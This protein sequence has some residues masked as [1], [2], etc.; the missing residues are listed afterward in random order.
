MPRR[1]PN[2]GTR[3]WLASCAPRR[4]RGLPQ[5]TV[6]PERRQLREHVISRRQLPKQSPCEPVRF[7]SRRC[8]HNCLPTASNGASRV[9]RFSEQGGVSGQRHHCSLTPGNGGAVTSR[10]DMRA[11]NGCMNMRD[12]EG[13]GWE[14]PR[15]VS[16]RAPD[17]GARRIERVDPHALLAVGT[18][19][20]DVA[21]REVLEFGLLLASGLVSLFSGLVW[22]S[23]L[24]GPRKGGPRL[25]TG[26]STP[27]SC[28]SAP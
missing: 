6:L 18:H 12:T 19:R 9:G 24:P 10:A 15:R 4:P 25:R 7:G 20:Y 28:A 26:T 16:R 23:F 13:S 1:W 27:P 5:L 14:R 8:Q 2:P 17:H 21:Q 11:M 22:V 3:S